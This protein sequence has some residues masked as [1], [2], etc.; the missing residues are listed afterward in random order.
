MKEVTLI[1]GWYLWPTCTQLY[2]VVNNG[3]RGLYNGTL[4]YSDF[5][6]RYYSL[7]NSSRS[8]FKEEGTFIPLQFMEGLE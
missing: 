2:K 6:H 3:E 5:D 8:T 1:D 4:K 7:D